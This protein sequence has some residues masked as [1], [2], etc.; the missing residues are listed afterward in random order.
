MYSVRSWRRGCGPTFG[1]GV[2]YRGAG[3]GG[4]RFDPGALEH[5]VEGGGVLAGAAVDHESEPVG[6]VHEQVSGGL[7]GPGPGGVGGAPA[8]VQ[9]AGADLDEE[10]DVEALEGGGVD[11]AEVG[12]DHGSGLG[13]DELRPGG[14]GPVGGGV[15]AGVAEDLPHARGGDLVAQA[16]QFAVDAPVAP[17]RVLA[18]HG[19]G[20]SAD[21]RMHRRPPPSR[22][23]GLG[24]AAGDEAAVPAD[25]RRRLHDEE[26]SAKLCQQQSCSSAGGR[27]GAGSRMARAAERPTEDLDVILGHEA[28]PGRAALEAVDAIQDDPNSLVACGSSSTS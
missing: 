12:D 15:D 3:W 27:C 5:G 4:D 23:V 11:T 20:E 16:G 1:V 10:Q 9:A 22:G 17:R 7:G 19:D 24:P 28:R 26:P 2:G 25:H 18:G 13:A 21:L 14:P 8:E 6:E